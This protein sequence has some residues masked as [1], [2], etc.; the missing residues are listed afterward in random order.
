MGSESLQDVI[1]EIEQADANEPRLANL[2]PRSPTAQRFRQSN[3]AA[4]RIGNARRPQAAAA[5]SAAKSPAG[6]SGNGTLGGRSRREATEVSDPE[7]E[8][9]TLSGDGSAEYRA[10]SREIAVDDSQLVDWQATDGVGAPAAP[11]DDDFS[12]LGRKR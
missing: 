2:R 7:P 12:D 6:T 3:T 4:T 5:P 1:N 8:Q 11:T 10:V 9:E